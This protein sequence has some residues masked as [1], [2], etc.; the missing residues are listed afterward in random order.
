MSKLPVYLDRLPACDPHELRLRVLPHRVHQPLAPE[1]RQQRLDLWTCA[2]AVLVD[3]VRST[4]VLAI[5]PLRDRHPLR[6]RHTRTLLPA[7]A[8]RV[9]RAGGEK[10]MPRATLLG[11][12]MQVDEHTHDLRHDAHDGDER[13]LAAADDVRLDG[14]GEVV[15]EG[16]VRG[17]GGEGLERHGDLGGALAALGEQVGHLPA[18]QVGGVDGAFFAGAEDADDAAEGRGAAEEGEEVHDEAGARVGDERGGVVEVFGGFC[19]GGGC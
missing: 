15:D 7:L 16:H 19:R 4:P 8:R 17:L 5:H 13:G 11:R 6:Q 2:L 10:H 18:L 14:A 1:A 12:D 3:R 9:F